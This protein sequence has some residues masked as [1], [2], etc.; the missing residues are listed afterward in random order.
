MKNTPDLSEE[1]NDN[2]VAQ[3]APIAVKIE[4]TNN[5]SDEDV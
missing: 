3:E 4:V 2:N 1:C 5:D